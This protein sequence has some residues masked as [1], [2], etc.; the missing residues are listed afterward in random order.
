VTESKDR[1]EEFEAAV[2]AWR[3]A[4]PRVLARAEA[5]PLFARRWDGSVRHLRGRGL[6]FGSAATGLHQASAFTDETETVVSID[7]AARESR[8]ADLGAPTGHG[9]DA[10]LDGLNDAQREAVTTTS[11]AL[12][13]LAGAGTGKTRVV[14][15]RIAYALA[16]GIVRADEALVVTFTEKA[17]REMADRLATLGQP[18][19]TART[20]HAAAL[21]QLRFFWPRVSETPFPAILES[22]VP[23]LRAALARENVP[24]RFMPPRDFADAIEWAKVRRLLPRDLERAA[25][26]ANRALPAP[27]DVVLRAWSG[28]ERAKD[29]AGRIDFED[30]LVRTVEMLETRADIAEEV[31][32]RYRWFSVD[33]YQDTN[34]VQE[35]L[36]RLWLG[37]RHD[38]C[39][40][41][42]PDQMIYSFTGA[43]SEYLTSFA[44]RHPGARVIELR[45]NYRS[46]RQIIALG[47]RLATRSLAGEP[48]LIATH[49]AGPD[50][51]LVRF[52]SEERERDGLVDEL[53]RLLTEGVSPSEC[54]VLVRV[55]A[56]L[57]P[58]AEALAR[59]GI[60]HRTRGE[61][62]FDGHDVRDAVAVL[63][64]LQHGTRS[65]PVADLPDAI[66]AAWGRAL[67]YERGAD[68]ATEAARE[69]QAA[70]DALLLIAVD[71]GT[72]PP[73]GEPATALGPPSVDVFLAEL[74]RRAGL[75]RDGAAEGVTLS[76]IHRAK[77]LEWDA[78]FL[79]SWEEGLMPHAAA[80]GAGEVAE[81]RRLAY[82][83]ITR[84]RVHLWIGW[85]ARRRG[86]R[87]GD[88]ARTRSRFLDEI[89][90]ASRRAAPGGPH[91]ECK[92][93]AVSGH[94]ALPA[95]S[96]G[97][98]SPGKLPAGD[99][100]VEALRAWRLQ[101][102]TADAVPAYF[103]FSDATLLAI[104]EARPTSP[105]DLLGITGVGPGK[106][107]RYGADILAICRTHPRF[108]ARQPRV[109]R[110]GR[111]IVHSPSASRI[112]IKR[113]APLETPMPMVSL[114]SDASDASKRMSM[115]GDEREWV[116]ADP[117]ESQLA[118]AVG[119]PAPPKQGLG[120]AA[121][122]CMHGYARTNCAHC[123]PDRFLPPVKT[124]RG[125]PKR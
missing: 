95:G 60:P 87:G 14:T 38:L 91:V 67:G 90:P 26:V 30:L 121:R 86:P 12:A 59:A 70:L 34:A 62:F 48:R 125:L 23:L 72:A 39:V 17:A 111:E 51:H 45:Q 9:T 33:E 71:L 100:L 5:D 13:I 103:V 2:T 22:K 74:D 119:S 58:I 47:N 112:V 85:S 56:Q 102:C 114:T 110:L 1:A 81:E 89:A 52:A 113:A 32:S 63:R 36:L 107:E 3:Q 117:F 7:R 97:E 109:P 83:A 124:R 118:S 46:T 88:N 29:R 15:Q 98:R 78:V 76:T 44:E 82:V 43:S 41:G 18:R 54:A 66:A 65:E 4:L 42:D 123:R 25:A 55:N 122:T 106:K 69:R 93:N 104:A 84:A 11:G 101:R 8:G 108:V 115:S 77:G 10:L 37:H 116:Q 94:S 79:P 68:A 61:R 20:F 57:E 105:S 120:Q 49:P 50:P 64:R 80:K 19:V 73:P 53:R 75:E 35:D 40:V 27:A 16:T 28:Y 6:W 24:Y 92:A 21:R 31:R 96:K 99:P